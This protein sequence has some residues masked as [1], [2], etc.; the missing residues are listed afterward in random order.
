MSVAVIALCC[1][2]TFVNG[3]IYSLLQLMKK[4][5]FIRDSGEDPSICLPET[6]K[7]IPSEFS[8]FCGA[9]GKETVNDHNQ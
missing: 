2:L 9:F 8:L 3:N 5:L 6:P 1:N 7:G 4:K